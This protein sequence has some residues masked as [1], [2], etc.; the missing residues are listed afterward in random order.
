M[1]P[2]VKILHLE[3][4]P[5]DA[6][7]VGRQL[8]TA[9]FKFEI[10]VIETREDF[11]EA[12]DNYKPDIILSDHT[13]PQFN[14]M[15]ALRIYKERQCEIPF[16]LITGSVSEEFAI[17]SIKEGADDYILKSNLI[18]LPASITQA[19]K[20]RKIESE[21]HKANAELERINKE[22]STFI[23]K[24][25]HDLRGPVC[26]IMGLLNVAG[27]QKDTAVLPDFLTKISESTT[28]LDSI[29]LSLME[30]MSIKNV[31]PILR[32]IDFDLLV[33]NILARLKM[34]PGFSTITFHTEIKDT[35]GFFSDE[36]ILNAVL[37]NIIENA[38]KFSNKSSFKPYVIIKVTSVAMGIE[39][40]VKDNGVGMSREVREKIF[41]MYFKGNQFSKNPGLGLYVAHNGVKKLGGTISVESAP[42][43]GSTFTILFPAQRIHK[44]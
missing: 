6:F 35:G 7:L 43:S 31:A 28:K 39:I 37:F 19:I 9:S 3:D 4:N 25:A 8:K 2:I 16:I 44:S 1:E 34:T 15:D 22:L 5:A 13:L 33:K 23:Y 29:L 21:R 40:Q 12:L 14:S 27:M 10:K 17:R 41:E 32:E 38:V 36:N 11:I 30:V 18:R 26:S 24:A 42:G 20:A